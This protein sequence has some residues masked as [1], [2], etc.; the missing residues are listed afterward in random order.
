M[1]NLKIIEKIKKYIIPSNEEYGMTAYALKA[2][3]EH[4]LQE[5]ISVEQFQ[6]AMIQSG[7]KPIKHPDYNHH[8]LIEVVKSPD[9]P[10]EYWGHGYTLLKD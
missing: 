10:S 7:F 2:A 8:Y 3:F 1:D 5:Y 9:I 4:I 6:E